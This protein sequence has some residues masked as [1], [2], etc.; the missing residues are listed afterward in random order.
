[1]IVDVVPGGQSISETH[2]T[3]REHAASQPLAFADARGES[4]SGDPGL[5][6]LLWSVRKP[7]EGVEKVRQI[8][9]WRVEQTSTLLILCS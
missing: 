8:A 4:S 2:V 5:M 3:V 6:V 7:F 9:F 1:M